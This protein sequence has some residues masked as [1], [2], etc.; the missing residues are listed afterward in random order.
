MIEDPQGLNQ[1]LSIS[2]ARVMRQL[3]P[4]GVLNGAMLCYDCKRRGLATGSEAC[5]ARPL[6]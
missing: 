6:P 3:S 4:K 5:E 2:N 1:P